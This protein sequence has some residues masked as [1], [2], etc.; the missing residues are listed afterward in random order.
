MSPT[1]EHLV[2]ILNRDTLIDLAGERSYERGEDYYARGLVSSIA[3]HAGTVT[4]KVRGTRDYRVKLW[5]EEGTLEYTC[6]C[7]VGDEGEF[8]KHCVAVALELLDRSEGK[9]KPEDS[10]TMDDVQSWLARQDKSVLVDMLMQQ[11]MSDDRLRE[12]LLMKATKESSKGID[13]D[14]F[15]RVIDDAAFTGDFVDYHEA[16]DYARGIEEVIDSLQEFFNEGYS[17]EV[18]ELTEYA[19]TRVENGIESVDDSDGRLSDI[20][21]MLQELHLEACRQAKPDPKDLAKRLFDWELNSEWDTFS[22]AAA[23]YADV[24]GEEGMKIYRELAET[25]WAKVPKLGPGQDPP[26]KYGKRFRITN[27]METLARE[28][29]DVEKLV[30]VMS[31]D[32]SSA[33]DYLQIANVYKEAGRNDPALEWAE[34]GIAAFPEH[35]DSRLRD[36]LAEEYFT[37][38]RHDEAMALYLGRVFGVAWITGLQEA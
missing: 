13:L 30:A 28:S 20:L 16:Y 2:D 8:C 22:G 3:E 37:R 18:I 35:T 1:L 9:Q 23:T 6:M 27:I 15:R 34:R 17:N 10:V 32:L 21:S 5:L 25:N 24:L 14:V 29:S 38:G 33:Y 26:D 19:L 36:F 31:R 12:R 4:A 11:A 7:P